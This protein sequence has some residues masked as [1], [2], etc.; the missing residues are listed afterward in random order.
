MVI[1]NTKFKKKEAGKL[2]TYISD[3]SG[4]KSQ[5][6][7]IPVN[8]KCKECWG[9]NSFASSDSDHHL[10]SARVKLSLRTSKTPAKGPR[11]DWKALKDPKLQ[12]QYLCQKQVQWT[13]HWSWYW[14][15]RILTPNSSQRQSC[16]K[17]LANMKE[18]AQETTRR[19][20]SCCE[21]KAKNTGSIHLL[22]E[23]SRQQST[24]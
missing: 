2:W 22:S 20:F 11:Y 8:I 4:T 6:Y 9:I 10:L 5:V 17:T 3:M 7:F 13:V 24:V 1:T 18:E 21:C 12:E 16:P 23:S 19:G 15:R 14:Y